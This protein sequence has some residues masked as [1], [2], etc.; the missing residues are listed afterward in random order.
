[1]LIPKDCSKRMR[2]GKPLTSFIS[3]LQSSGFQRMFTA[4]PGAGERA[5]DRGGWLFIHT[6]TIHAGHES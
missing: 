5:F 1:M 3:L 2:A 4:D 6:S